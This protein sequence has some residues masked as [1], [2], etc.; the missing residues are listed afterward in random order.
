MVN[1]VKWRIRFMAV[2]LGVAALLVAG[3]AQ[4]GHADSE[5]QRPSEQGVVL[6]LSDDISAVG[7][8]HASAT[9]RKWPRRTIT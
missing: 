8:V 5:G 3:L 9:V 4:I 1:T 2:L 6:D 7:G